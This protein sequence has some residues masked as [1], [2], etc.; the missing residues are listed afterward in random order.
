[1][2]RDQISLWLMVSG[3]YFKKYKIYCDNHFTIYVSQIIMLYL[4]LLT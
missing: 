1:M 4:K 3:I 2:K